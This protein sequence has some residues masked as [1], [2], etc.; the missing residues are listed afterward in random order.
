MVRPAARAHSVGRTP[1]VTTSH[2]NDRAGP[3]GGGSPG[4]CS[5][6]ADKSVA[7]AKGGRGQRVQKGRQRERH[8]QQETAER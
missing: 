3:G 2:P 4:A 5:Q 8:Y 1:Y 6:P 7:P